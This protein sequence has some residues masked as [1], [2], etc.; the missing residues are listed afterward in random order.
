VNLY[1]RTRTIYLLWLLNARIRTELEQA[2]SSITAT[3]GQYVVMSYLRNNRKYS[4]AEISRKTG[5]SAQST[6]ELAVALEKKGLI[7]RTPDDKNP[8]IL[9]LS[10]TLEGIELL[11]GIDEIVDELEGR[12]F[13]N[14]TPTESSIMR[15]SIIALLEDM[16]G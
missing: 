5:V 10:L 9:R 7:V 3:P 1:S 15:S 16:S 14:I 12:L 4:A 8:R 6:S 13:Q 11:A 2:F